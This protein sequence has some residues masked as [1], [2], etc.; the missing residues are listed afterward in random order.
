LR[1]SVVGNYK[2]LPLNGGHAAFR[3]IITMKVANNFRVTG[4]SIVCTN[5]LADPRLV[6]VRVGSKGE[7]QEQMLFC[8][9]SNN[10]QRST[11]SACPFGAIFRRT[12]HYIS[13]KDSTSGQ[14]VGFGAVIRLS[15]MVAKRAKYLITE[16]P[17]AI[18]G[19]R[20]RIPACLITPAFCCRAAPG[21]ANCRCRS[22]P[23]LP[24]GF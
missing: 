9:A 7:I 6:K 16:G 12:P 4:R 8:F 19:E 22:D 23:V 18:F 1:I 15:L 14:S 2:P 3:C 20:V 21:A 11:V 10:G 5:K 24:D 17:S 13:I